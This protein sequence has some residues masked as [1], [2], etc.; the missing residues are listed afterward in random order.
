[1]KFQSWY[2]YFVVFIVIV[3]ISFFILSFSLIY[4]KIKTHGQPETEIMKNL[5][6]WKERVE[7]VF[8]LDIAI[9]LTY[10]FY[11]KR[12][13]PIPI[14]NISRNLLFAYGILIMLTAK[15]DLF[16]K[17]DTVIELMN[18]GLKFL[19]NPFTDPNLSPINFL[20]GLTG[21]TSGV[22]IILL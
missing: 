8:I 5:T 17:E 20:L 13:K 12:E 7:F 14:D 18:S 1:M 11:P 9:L 22:L 3:K 2:D 21:S 4:L 15:W 16:F 19:E 10:L 6:Y